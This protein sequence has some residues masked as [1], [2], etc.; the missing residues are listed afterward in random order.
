MRL[1]TVSPRNTELYALRLLLLNTPGPKCYGDLKY[2]N[3][4]ECASFAKAA[5][6][7]GLLDCDDNWM[8]VMKDAI[9]ANINESKR[10]SHFAQLLFFQPPVDAEQMLEVFL[11]E[12]LPQPPNAQDKE[13]SA[14]IRKQIV[15]RKLEYY[16][17]KFGSS[18]EYVL[19]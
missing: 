9:N 10:I 17:S 13:V 2:A 12:L 18:C 7:R 16:L 15:L 11:D 4:V 14:K 5:E 1:Y 6:K 8:A 19:S 3:G